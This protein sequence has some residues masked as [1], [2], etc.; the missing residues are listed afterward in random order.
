MDVLL[1][2]AEGCQTDL[3]TLLVSS[4]HLYDACDKSPRETLGQTGAI[5]VLPQDEMIQ[6]EGQSWGKW[7][8]MVNIYGVH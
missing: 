1:L 6:K 7:N 8:C 4:N 3:S 2:R 5:E